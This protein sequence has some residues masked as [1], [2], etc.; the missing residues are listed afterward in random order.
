[1]AKK[2][3][4]K[5]RHR[6]TDAPGYLGTLNIGGWQIAVTRVADLTDDQGVKCSGLWHGV[7]RTIQ[8][9]A[10]LTP[11]QEREVFCHE[12]FHGICRT[13]G[14]QLDEVAEELLA[15]VFGVALAQTLEPFLW[16][17]NL[18]PWKD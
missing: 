3:A 18:K 17:G 15:G 4:T 14:M 12:I 10:D 2:K 5:K 8:L 16:A 11:S 7:N 13:Y 6:Q 1:M 9:D